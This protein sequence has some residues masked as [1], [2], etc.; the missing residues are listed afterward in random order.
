MDARKRFRRN[1]G[2]N[3]NTNPVDD[4]KKEVKAAVQSSVT[5]NKFEVLKRDIK[6]FVSSQYEELFVS[7]YEKDVEFILE[8]FT[9]LVDLRGRSNSDEQLEAKKTGFANELRRF[10][11]PDDEIKKLFRIINKYVDVGLLSE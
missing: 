6:D 9:E 4:I 10:E 7:L 5:L 2:F 3:V 1:P 8:R 11:Y